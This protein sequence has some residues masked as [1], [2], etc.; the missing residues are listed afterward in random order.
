L[1]GFYQHLAIENPLNNPFSPD[2]VR[3][4]SETSGLDSG[5]LPGTS[6]LAPPLEEMEPGEIY[7]ILG[8][9]PDNWNR[10]KCDWI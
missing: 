6:T 4:I 2:L 1:P 9:W 8:L 7:F 3:E 5:V 10:G